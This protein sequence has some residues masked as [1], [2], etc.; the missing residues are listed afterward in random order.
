MA[1]SP[2]VFSSENL[3]RLKAKQLLKA[4]PFLKLSAAQEATANALGYASWYE[5]AHR[6]TTGERSLQDEQAGTAVRVGRYYHQAGVLMGL[7]IA[8]SESDRWVR[9]WGLTGKP[10]LAREQGVAV[11]YA[12]ND[13]IERLERGEIGEQE[14]RDEFGADDSKYPDIDLP[15]RVCPGV[16]LAPCGKYPHY[17]VD[18]AIHA[19]IPIYLRGPSNLYHYEDDGDVLA[20]SIPGFAEN[21]HFSPEEPVFPRLN[22]IQYEWHHGVKHPQSPELCMPKL[23]SA[24]LAVPEEMI[25]ISVRA[26]PGPDDSLDFKRS[27]VA[28]LRGRDFL[29]FLRSKGALDPSRVVWYRDVKTRDL[30]FSMD[31]WMGGWDPSRTLPLFAQ[32]KKLSPGLPLYSYPFMAAPMHRDEYSGGVERTCLL[33]LD[34]D[35]ADPYDDDDDGESPEVEPNGMADRAEEFFRTHRH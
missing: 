11:Y 31:L 13:A 34:E 15:Q 19:R 7:G 14:V 17:A 24:A 30:G 33:P 18:P 23:E 9:A 22:R 27:A 2:F 26:T 8:P 10:T 20:M 5:C 3:P 6:G 16:I 4:F 1:I 21:A 29:A 12:W 32:A 28:C 35:Y 25:V